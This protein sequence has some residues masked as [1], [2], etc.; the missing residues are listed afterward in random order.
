MQLP[1]MDQQH[2]LAASCCLWF[3]SGE[4][5]LKGSLHF[6]VGIDFD[7]DEHIVCLDIDLDDHIVA[8]PTC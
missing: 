6:D 8:G 5:G 1:V 2:W 7:V 3:G 4:G